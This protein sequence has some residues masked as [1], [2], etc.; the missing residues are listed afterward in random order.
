MHHT[1]LLHFCEVSGVRESISMFCKGFIIVEIIYHTFYRLLTVQCFL[2][3]KNKRATRERLNLASVLC[4]GRTNSKST[5]SLTEGYN[6]R[7]MR[8]NFC[9]APLMLYT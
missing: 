1:N 2:Q 7:S 6:F 8:E 5:S 9:Y 3:W 4:D